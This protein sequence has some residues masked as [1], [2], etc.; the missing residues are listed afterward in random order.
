MAGI[1][2]FI[3]LYAMDLAG[4][5]K[6]IVASLGSST[7]VV[8]AAPNSYTARLRSLRGGNLTGLLT[9]AFIS[10]VL[11]LSGT[12]SAADWGL[13]RLIAGASAVMVSMFVMSITDTEHPPAAGLAMGLV[14]SQWYWSN[15]LIIIC[16]VGFL[17]LVKKHFTG[18]MLN[19]Y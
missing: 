4:Q 2:I 16:S 13:E 6:A 18:R 12:D 17:S 11:W 8:F 1:V 15:V 5:N 3:I 9:G 7:F 10:L 19:L 14:I